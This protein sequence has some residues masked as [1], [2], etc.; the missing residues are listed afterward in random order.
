VACATVRVPKQLRFEHAYVPFD[1]D[2]WK[3]CYLALDLVLSHAATPGAEQGTSWTTTFLD[4]GLGEPALLG[5][6]G[7]VPELLFV[8]ERFTVALLTVEGNV[9]DD[10]FARWVA[11]TSIALEQSDLDHLVEIANI[12]NEARRGLFLWLPPA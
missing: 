7:E 8:P 4:R 9:A 10:V 11:A 2:P 6:A 5:P 3:Q 12:A 1:G